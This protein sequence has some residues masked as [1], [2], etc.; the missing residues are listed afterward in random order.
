[1][2]QMKKQPLVTVYIPTYNRLELLKRAVE[3]VLNQDYKNIELIV[4]DDGSNDGTVEYLN[5]LSKQHKNFRF[6]VNE[7]NSGACV[8]RNKAIWAASGEFITGLDD[9]DEFSK[10]RI[11]TFLNTPE[12]DSYSYLCSRTLICR[13][14]KKYIGSRKTGTIN[15]HDLLNKNIVGNQVFT[16]TTG[17]RAINGFDEIFP[18]WQD[19]DTWLRL[20]LKF[21]P[22]YKI[23]KP[24]YI[25]YISQQIDSITNN[26]KKDIGYKHF[27]AKHKKILSKKNMVS[28]KIESAINSRSKLDKKE[29]IFGL[30]NGKYEQLL[31]YLVKRLQI[32]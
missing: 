12:L 27:V 31:R 22:G 15:K 13:E 18:A 2:T 32:L 23:K 10:D 3:S 29:I 7:V 19:Y 30:A 6:F 14:K 28:L 24:T 4:V 11:S 17:L 5:E 21:G 8:S 25:T 1:M 20:T 9:D 26:T 16:K